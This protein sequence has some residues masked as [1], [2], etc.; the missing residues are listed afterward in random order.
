MFKK[1]PTIHFIF[2]GGAIDSFY[3][4]I[5]DTISPHKHSVI[6]DYIKNLKLYDKVV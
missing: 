1:E 6:P 2:T 5:K 4:G 3:N